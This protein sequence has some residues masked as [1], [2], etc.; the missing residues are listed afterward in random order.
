MRVMVWLMHKAG[1]PR[2]YTTTVRPSDELL[3]SWKSQGFEVFR[4]SIYL[5]V[6][7]K[8]TELQG[9]AFTEEE[10]RALESKDGEGTGQG[11]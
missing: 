9:A 4:A 1:E 8:T 10:W 3:N 11:S 5:P 6:D 2:T 7:G